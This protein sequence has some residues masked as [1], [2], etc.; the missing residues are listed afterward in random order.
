MKTVLC[1]LAMFLSVCA[2]DL[3]K[4]N[5]GADI[6]GSPKATTTAKGKRSNYPFSGEVESHDGKSLTLKGKK[7]SRVLLLT[8]ETR[9]LKDGAVAKLKDGEY[10]SGSA[11]KNAEGKE[12]ALTVNLKGQKPVK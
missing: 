11:R 3:E 6:S 2:S 10:V 8:S 5:F 9:V 12:E 4:G 1:A 7:K